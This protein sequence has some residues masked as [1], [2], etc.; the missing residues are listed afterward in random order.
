EVGRIDGII[1]ILKHVAEALFTLPQS[2]LGLHQIR[3][4][5]SDADNPH[6]LSVFVFN[7][8]FR[9]VIPSDS[10]FAVCVLFELLY[11]R[12]AG[13]DDLLLER[14]KTMSLLRREYVKICFARHFPRVR[15]AE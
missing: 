5:P 4:V 6:N 3:N 1:R 8:D 13:L 14:I 11:Q 10:A 9:G 12:L 15:K 7:G 2:S